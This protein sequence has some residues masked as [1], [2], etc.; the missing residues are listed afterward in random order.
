[1]KA[2]VFEGIGNVSVKSVPDPQV[3]PGGVILKVEACTICGT[4][5]RIFRNGHKKVSFP[6][7][8]GHEVCGTVV[9][10]GKGANV[11]IGERVAVMPGAHCGNCVYCVNG[12]RHQCALKKSIGYQLPGGFAEY[13]ALPPEFVTHKM[14]VAV[15]EGVASKHAAIMEPIGVA[16]HAHDRIDTRLNDSVVILG[17]GP[18]GAI[19]YEIARLRG[20]MKII[21]ADIKDERLEIMRKHYPSAI[22]V[23]SRKVDLE[24]FVK[25]QTNGLGADAVIVSNSSPEAQVQSIRL[26]A[27][28]GRV[29][30]FGGLPEDRRIIELDSNII[31]YN[32]LAVYGL[33]GTT[34]KNNYQAM[35][36]LKMGLFNMDA[37]VSHEYPLDDIQK[38]LELVEKGETMRVAINPHL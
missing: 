4:D 29:M 38:A 26:A 2:A 17:A 16:L 30:F 13:I 10:A 33:N 1:M 37:I 8:L 25:E 31:H 6:W 3:E 34:M 35:E 32:D 22:L 11:A 19:H 20:A 21:V 5:I 24:N 18:I 12:R 28:R 15:P 14:L 23:N 9:E 7:I 36:I 27:P